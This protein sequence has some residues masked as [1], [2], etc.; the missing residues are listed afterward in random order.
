MEPRYAGKLSVRCDSHDAV[1]EADEIFPD[2]VVD[3][4][5]GGGYHRYIHVT[6]FAHTE[7]T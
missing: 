1:E 2:Q 5:Y 4:Q 7:T 6:N 3:D